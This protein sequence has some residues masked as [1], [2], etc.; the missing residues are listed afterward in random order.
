MQQSPPQST[1][2]LGGGRFI[3][4]VDVHNLSTMSYFRRMSFSGVH[5]IVSLCSCDILRE[6]Y[7]DA[8]LGH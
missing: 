4:V 6:S 5:R 2:R 7:D 1:S 8:S 3:E